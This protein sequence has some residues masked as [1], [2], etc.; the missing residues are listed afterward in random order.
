MLEDHG[1][2]DPRLVAALSGDDHAEV[3]AALVDARV[4]AAIT[5]TATGTE[6]GAHGL[7]Q[8]SSAEM[9]VVLLQSA[10]GTRALPVFTDL[11]QLKRWR[12][13]ARPVPLTGPQACQAAL[14]ERADAI[15]LDPAGAGVTVSELG[16]L[17]QGFVPVPGSSL[18]ARRAD[19]PL[20]RPTDVPEGLVAALRA[21]LRAEPLHAARLLES[22]EGLV[23]GVVPSVDLGPAELAALAQRLMASLGPALPAAGLDL[24]VVAPTG[25]GLDLLTRRR[26]FRRP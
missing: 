6:T 22:D 19:T 1:T 17:A 5:A 20:R 4:F 15:V 9:A 26:F 3:L 10:D 23:L 13:D 7:R 16:P 14:D 18:S 12:L 21:A 25:P 24:A 8:E 11:G 2:A